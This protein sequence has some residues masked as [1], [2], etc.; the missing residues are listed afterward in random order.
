[1]NPTD[2]R[3]QTVNPPP[4]DGLYS[5]PVTTGVR[6]THIPSGLVAEAWMGS[7]QNKKKNIAIA[8]L[9]RGLAEMGW[10]G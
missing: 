2:L 8:M 6:V 1:M 9:E 5:H 7:S 3:I 10:K 4:S